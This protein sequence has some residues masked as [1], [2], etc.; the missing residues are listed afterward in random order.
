VPHSDPYGR[1]GAMGMKGSE[2]EVK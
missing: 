1:R 2:F